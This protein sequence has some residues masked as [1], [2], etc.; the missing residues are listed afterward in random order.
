MPASANK[1]KQDFE[2]SFALSAIAYFVW[3]F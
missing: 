1:S 3:G 2:L